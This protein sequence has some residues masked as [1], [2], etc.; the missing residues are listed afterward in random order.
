ML[1]DLG[2]ELFIWV[3]EAL[4]KPC[5]HSRLSREHLHKKNTGRPCNG[6]SR[7]VKL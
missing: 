6:K 5:L 1:M 4:K 3:I 7:E 2:E